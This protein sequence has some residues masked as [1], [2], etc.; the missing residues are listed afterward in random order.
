MSLRNVTTDFQKSRTILVNLTD[1]T[2]K[3]LDDGVV[4]FETRSVIG[5]NKDDQR[6][7]EFSDVMEHMVINPSWYLPRSITV[8]E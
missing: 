1:F 8:K 3:I 2:A 5:T 4:T 6:S 7:P